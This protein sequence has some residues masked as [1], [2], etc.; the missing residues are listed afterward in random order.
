M[1][2]VEKSMLENIFAGDGDQRNCGIVGLVIGISLPFSVTPAGA[3]V[4]AA[5]ILTGASMNCF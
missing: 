3:G 5:A 2:K 1:K 4:L